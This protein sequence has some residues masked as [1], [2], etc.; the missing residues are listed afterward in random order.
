MRAHLHSPLIS[1]PRKNAALR[2]RSIVLESLPQKLLAHAVATEKPQR[3]GCSIRG[4]SS[5]KQWKDARAAPF[6]A[7]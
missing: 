6:C 4:V 1:S 3:A 2:T 5:L 7:K